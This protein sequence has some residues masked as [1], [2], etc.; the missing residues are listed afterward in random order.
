MYRP[1]CVRV[2]SQSTPT[3][4]CLNVPAAAVGQREA[5]ALDAPEPRVLEFT[6]MP[7][8]RLTLAS[9][10]TT[11]AAI[12]KARSIRIRFLDNEM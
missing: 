11:A 2:I 3:E 7:V 4:R 12:V 6:A 8:R 1:P 5:A 10:A 9:A